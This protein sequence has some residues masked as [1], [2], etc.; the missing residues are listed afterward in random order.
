MNNISKII[1]NSQIMEKNIKY[2]ITLCDNLTGKGKQHR[3]YL[4]FNSK[5][6]CD[7]CQRIMCIN[8]IQKD[9]K[10]CVM[11][12][13]QKNIEYHFGLF[14]DICQHLK[15]MCNDCGRLYCCDGMKEE[16]GGI[17]CKCGNDMN[18]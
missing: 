9:G 2:V 4:S 16:Y 6:K 3:A 7:E 11:C 8:C 12:S 18:Y 14:D 15:N 10:C 5:I 17:M 13:K 1:N